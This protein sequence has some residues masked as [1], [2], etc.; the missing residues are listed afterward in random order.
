MTEIRGSTLAVK[1]FHTRAFA[2]L[3]AVLRV[4]LGWQW[5]HSGWGKLFNPAWMD[6][7]SALQ[8]FLSRATVVPETGRPPVVYDWYRSFL[9]ALLDGGHYT[10]F[11]KLVVFGE[12]LVGIGLILGAFTAIAAFFG[13]VMN[14]SFMLA[15][16]A[17]TNPVLFTA[18]ILLMVAWK[19]AGWYGVDRWLLYEVGTPWQP[20]RTL[21]RLF[22]R[23]KTQ[24]Q[25]G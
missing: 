21:A 5:L 12:I 23:D 13:A 3:W 7:G 6:G 25:V 22:R 4:W 8:G 2:W 17:S 15:G 14:I 11:A 9:Q 20:G 1:L 18:S 19:V 16:T 24:P 10:W